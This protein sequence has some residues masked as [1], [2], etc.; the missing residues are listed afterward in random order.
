MAHSRIIVPVDTC[1]AYIES[2]GWKLTT[3][4]GRWYRFVPTAPRSDGKTGI[5][6]TTRELRDAY[7]FGW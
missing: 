1:I 6:F 2:C 7:N 4:Q 5:P 3:R